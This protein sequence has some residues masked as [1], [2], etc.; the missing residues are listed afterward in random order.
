MTSNHA[1]CDP[2]YPV[3]EPNFHFS[4]GIFDR[5]FGIPFSADNSLTHI[6]D[7]YPTEILALYRFDTLIPLYPTIVSF[8]QIRSLV[9]H[10]IPFH[11]MQHL[12]TT[13]FISPPIISSSHNTGYINIYTQC[14]SPFFTLQPMPATTHWKK[15]YYNDPH[16][17]VLIDH[18]SI[19]SPL[20]IPTILQF[21]AT[22][23]SA[24]ARNLIGLLEGR[25]VY[26]D[27]ETTVTNHM[28][29]IVVPFSL[30][31]TI[32]SLIHATPVAGYMGECKTLYRIK[33]N[34][35]WPRL[36]SD[37]AEWIK[38]CPHCMFIYQK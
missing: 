23:R 33:L 3:P 30:R 29:R 17:R 38:R 18:L 14:V 19:N 28:Y 2:T 26:Y 1:I 37:V 16:T 24:I 32:F 13:L 27:P 4:D 10:T 25:L 7:P 31:R 22:Y 6:R 11:V 34:F 9:L 36:C 5:W 8:D 12:T 20:H 35:F 21:P 15:A